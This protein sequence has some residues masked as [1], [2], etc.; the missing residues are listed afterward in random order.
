LTFIFFSGV[1]TT[2]QRRT[3]KFI[4]L[5]RPFPNDFCPN[6]Y[7]AMLENVRDVSGSNPHGW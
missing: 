4:P 1:E 5:S 3:S 7:G 6:K 2:N